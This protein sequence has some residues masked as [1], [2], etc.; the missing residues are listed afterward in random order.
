MAFAD[1][2]QPL[3]FAERRA[4]ALRIRDELEVPLPILIDGMD[5][6]SRALFSDL[7]SPAFVIDR[8]GKIAD[9][10][11]WADPAPLAASIDAVLVGQ[12]IPAE[13]AASWS[14][15]Q[16]SSIAQRLVLDGESQLALDWLDTPGDPAPCVPPTLVAVARAGITRVHALRAAGSKPDAVG[17]AIA[18]A[19]AAAQEAWPKDP[20]RRVAALT[21]LAELAPPNHALPLWRAAAESLEPQAPESVRAFLARLARGR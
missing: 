3:T 21:E 1:V 19:Q 13:I 2:A 16:R 12:Q 15:D 4:L 5:D 9:K 17:A 11:P 20:A 7:P 6:A 18:A 10:L 8:D 14:L